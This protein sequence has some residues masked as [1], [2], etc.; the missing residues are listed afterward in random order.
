MKVK[1]I[2]LMGMAAVV[3]TACSTT[4]KA[5][6]EKKQSITSLTSTGGTGNDDEQIDKHAMASQNNDFA[7][8]LFKETVGMDSKVISPLSV[9]YLMSVLAN[10]ADGVTRQEIVKTLGWESYDVAKINRLC[11]SMM[12]EMATQ[13]KSTVM[14]SANY[15]AVNKGEELLPSFISNVKDAYGAGIEQLDFSSPTALRT[16][17]DWCKT[18]TDGMI[19]KLL[20]ELNP[21]AVSYVMN[22]IYFNGSWTSKFDKAQTK[23]ERFKGYT[24]DIKQ[25]SMMH[26]HAYYSYYDNDVFSAVN[27]PYGN[28]SF[29]FTAILP[30]EGKSVKEVIDSLRNGGM[31]KMHTG[32]DECEVDLK[33]PKF[34]T[35]SDQLLNDV[36]GKL[37]APSIFTYKANFSLMCKTPLVVSQMFQKA[38]IEVSE[39]GTKAAAVTAAVMMRASFA[40]HEKRKVDF[41][42]NRPFIYVITDNNTGAI[43]FIGQYAG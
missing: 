7:L 6:T 35:E 37:G 11:K 14:K 41:H 31:T 2:A 33:L 34:T 36:V 28:R 3:A 32:W 22:A 23:E 39:E 38:K 1:T 42:A 40:P 43:L 12:S 9:T 25:V 18:N 8:S 24:R 27:I 13:D 21:A 30:A 19:P 26:R 29:A 4:K 20:D 17:N 5:V 10:G 16:I 15:V